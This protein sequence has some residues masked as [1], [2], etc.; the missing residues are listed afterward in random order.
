[1]KTL[2]LLLLAQDLSETA[3]FERAGTFFKAGSYYEAYQEY[4]TF[5]IRFPQSDR[6]TAAKRMQMTSALDLARVGRKGFL[7]VFTSSRTGM[8]FLRDTLRRHPREDFSADFTQKLGMVLYERGDIDHAVEEFSRVLE[9]YGDAADAVLALYMLGRSSEIRFEAVDYDM[10]PLKDARR[11]YERFLEEADR[12]RRLPPPARTWVDDLLPTVSER[13]TKVYERM[14]QKQL[15]TA[16]YYDWKGASRSSTIY[17]RAIL[18]EEEA[19]RKV[20]RSFP[21][22][23][24][25]RKARLR[26]AERK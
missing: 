22:T 4:E 8:D 20:L 11:H 6:V 9:L 15:K 1:M 23:P 17:Y 18:K 24:A 26:L 3:Q 5:L 16:E 21:D 2:L 25:S 12:M 7:G 14:V 19:F 13:L 10:K